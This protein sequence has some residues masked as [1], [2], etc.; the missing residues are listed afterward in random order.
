ML[1]ENYL[2]SI[3]GRQIVDEQAGEIEV[4]TLGSYVKK[5]NARYIVYKEYDEEDGSSETSILKVDSNSHC[6]TLMRG[7]ADG[8]RLILEKGRRH[9]CNYSTAVGNM[10]MGVFT[11]GMESTLDDNGGN[12]RVNYTLDLDANLS[13]INEILV[14]VKEAD[15]KHVQT[16]TGSDGAAAHG[17]QPGSGE[18][19]EGRQPARG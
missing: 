5:G 8:T 19:A 15:K 13:S 14:T 10:T 16:R 6:V 18:S 1:E 7:G 3:R 4:T 17:D 12:V 9:L 2:I 11:S